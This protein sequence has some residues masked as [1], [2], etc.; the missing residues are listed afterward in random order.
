MFPGKVDCQ[1][2][3]GGHA[4][5]MPVKHAHGT[6]VTSYDGSSN[7]YVIFYCPASGANSAS[8]SSGFVISTTNSTASNYT[9]AILNNNSMATIY[10]GD[11]NVYSESGFVYTGLMKLTLAAPA[12]T[13][14]RLAYTGKLN[15]RQL[16]DGISLQQ[17]IATGKPTNVYA[18]A[19]A[20]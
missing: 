18:L 4:I 6:Y 14:T 17:L 1:Y 3:A 2:M 7:Y 15:Y 5:N 9:N 11:F 20:I 13:A 10:S 16:S 12:A 8:W 19:S